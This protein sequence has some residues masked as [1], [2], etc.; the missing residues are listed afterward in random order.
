MLRYYT[1]N[2]EGLDFN[3]FLKLCLLKIS[4]IYRYRGLAV[5]PFTNLTNTPNFVQSELA[6]LE[7]GYWRT[8]KQGYSSNITSIIDVTINQQTDNATVSM[9]FKTLEYVRDQSINFLIVYGPYNKYRR[10]VPSLDPIL[11]TISNNNFLNLNGNAS[12]LPN[13]YYYNEDHLNR[14][15]AP[16]Y[17]RFVCEK[18]TDIVLAGTSS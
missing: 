17:S 18:I 5:P 4:A 13:E 2:F 12:F 16:I 8:A 11:A 3:G 6:A 1:N 10:I 7:R 14:Y 9:F 15:G